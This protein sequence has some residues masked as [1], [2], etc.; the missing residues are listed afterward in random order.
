MNAPTTFRPLAE[1]QP[2]G[3]IAVYVGAGYNFLPHEKALVLFQQL[4][5]ALR[6]P[7]SEGVARY[8]ARML[9]AAR[10]DG[11][12]DID[13]ADAEEYALESELLEPF[14]A[15]DGG[16]GEHCL[17][18]DGDKCLRLSP[19]GRELMKLI[20]DEPEPVREVGR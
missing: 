11:G 9:A 13:G 19:L 20:D 7:Y 10:T 17:C 4:A 5:A 12:C 14:D 18:D 6:I 3:R 1:R 2:D 8:A 16:C 15:P